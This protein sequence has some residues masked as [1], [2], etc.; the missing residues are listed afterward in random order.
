MIIKDYFTD[1]IY[2]A[3]NLLSIL[4]TLFLFISHNKQWSLYSILS[5]IYN[6]YIPAFNFDTYRNTGESKS[7]LRKLES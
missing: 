1:C 4:H 5:P 2:V 6:S 3:D 7:G